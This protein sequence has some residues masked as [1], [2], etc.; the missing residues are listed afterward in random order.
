MIKRIFVLFLLIFVSL[1]MIVS[2]NADIGP[3]PTTDIEIIG[4]NESYYF[5]VLFKVDE[6]RVRELTESEVQEEI[7]HYYYRD[8][9]PNV[10]NGFQDDDGYASY[11]LYRGIPHHIE[12]RD[13]HKFHLGYVSPP[14]KFKIVLVLD[15]EEIIISNVVNKTLFNAEFTYDLND[16]DLEDAESELVDGVSVY[17]VDYTSPEEIIP[18]SQI[19][20]QI[21]L[22]VVLTVIIELGILFFFRYSQVKSYKIAL[23]VN[24]ITQFLF[25]TALILMSLFASFFG[26]IFIF[27]VGEIVIL[28]IEIILYRKYLKEKSKMIVTI[29][30]II[31]NLTSLFLGTYLLDLIL[32]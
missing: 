3:K 12:Q 11:T 5:D 24:L 8:D 16:F 7:E 21:I 10:L 17:Q 30:A 4:F 29:Y 31:A 27:V 14:D 13:T 25:H 18:W 23:Y 28:L 22:G 19:I 26:F 15:N 2:V 1:G 20:L 32:Y 6:S 9:F